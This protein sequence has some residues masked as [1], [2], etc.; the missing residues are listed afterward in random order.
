VWIHSK[1]LTASP[2]VVSDK[3]GHNFSFNEGLVGGAAWEE[4]G[5]LY[6]HTQALDFSK[7]H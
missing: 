5:G 3:F 2:N 6:A 7:L 1:A 4:K